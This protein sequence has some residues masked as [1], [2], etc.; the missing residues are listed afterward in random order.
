NSNKLPD[1]GKLRVIERKTGRTAG[2]TTD[3]GQ[4]GRM[5]EQTGLE[6]SRKMLLA[7]RG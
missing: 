2:R 5:T 3:S 7:N 1:F 4:T 6:T